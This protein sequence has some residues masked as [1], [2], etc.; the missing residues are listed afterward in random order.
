MVLLDIKLLSVLD[1]I[2]LPGFCCFVNLSAG[3]ASTKPSTTLKCDLSMSEC[4]YVCVCAR[5][6]ESVFECE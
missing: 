6:S 4:G 3:M 1:R 5:T 2:S